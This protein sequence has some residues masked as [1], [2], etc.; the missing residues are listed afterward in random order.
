MKHAPGFEYGPIKIDADGLN[1]DDTSLPGRPIPLM[2]VS[3]VRNPDR[4]STQHRPPPSAL[5]LTQDE[6]PRE[7]SAMCS[8][9]SAT[10]LSGTSGLESQNSGNRGRSLRYSELRK[11]LSTAI[12]TSAITSYS[13][14][15]VSARK[16][17][18]RSRTKFA[19]K[20]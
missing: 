16:C 9:K 15:D 18:F 8:E 2:Q 11:D 14:N 17:C 3:L 4:E 13:F 10:S 19:G 20:F 5:M 7:V 12:R 1:C 6:T